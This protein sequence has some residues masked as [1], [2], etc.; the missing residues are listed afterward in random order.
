M[1]R[2]TLLRNKTWEPFLKSPLK[3]A[4]Y[5]TCNRTDFFF[6]QVPVPSQMMGLLP[7]PPEVFDVC[8][9]VC[10]CVCV[11]LPCSIVSRRVLPGRVCAYIRV[12][13]RI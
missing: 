4:F 2:G 7:P 3:V 8:V 1:R 13:T 11:L 9:C 5:S 6:C 10:V 12:H